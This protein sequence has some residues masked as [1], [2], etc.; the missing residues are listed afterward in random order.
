VTYDALTLCY[1]LIIQGSTLGPVSYVVN[2][3]DLITV[4]LSILSFIAI[5]TSKV[6]YIMLQV[7]NKYEVD[8]SASEAAGFI[9]RTKLFQLFSPSL[10]NMTTA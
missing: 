5:I 4:T 1:K 2:A 7:A 8:Q 6:R 10:Y 9:D 3:G